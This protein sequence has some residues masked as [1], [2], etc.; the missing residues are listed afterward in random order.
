MPNRNG[1]LFLYRALFIPRKNNRVNI[2]DSYYSGGFYGSLLITVP[3]SL[4]PLDRVHNPIGARV[5]IGFITV[6]H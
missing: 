4:S 6:T 2:G 1:F 5:L 3:P